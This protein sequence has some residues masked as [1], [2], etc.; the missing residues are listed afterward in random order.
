M[1]IAL[2]RALY[3]GPAGDTTTHAHHALQL[4]VGLS[5]PVRLRASDGAWREHEAALVPSDVPHQLESSEEPVLLVYIEPESEDGRA[6]HRQPGAGI[7][8]V[9]ERITCAV[10]ACVQELARDDAGK[11]RPRDVFDRVLASA[12]LVAGPRAAVDP[13]IADALRRL[14]KPEQRSNSLASLAHEIGLSA[15]RFRHLFREQIG[16]STQ[17]YVVWLRL[18]E[19]ARVLAG[20]ATLGDAALEAGFSD[21]AHFTRT[22][23]RTFGLAPS[24]VSARLELMES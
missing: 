10:R 15:S 12:G 1:L 11:I 5:G 14:R 22:F 6:F 17:S 16:M 19:A 4:A 23:R 24:Q 8:A 21:A 3:L 7:V 2:G 13:R 9:D 18:Y 20:G